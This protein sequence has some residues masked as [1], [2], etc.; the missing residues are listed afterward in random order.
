MCVFTCA[1]VSKIGHCFKVWLRY[2]APVPLN[3]DTRRVRS[4]GR[5]KSERSSNETGST[6]YPGFRGAPSSGF[7]AGVSID[8]RAAGCSFTTAGKKY[9]SLN[10]PLLRPLSNSRAA[11]HDA[12]ESA[13]RACNTRSAPRILVLAVEAV[14]LDAA[15]RSISSLTIDVAF[16]YS[17]KM[18]R[19]TSESGGARIRR[20]RRRSPRG[21]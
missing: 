2:S 4:V 5:R 16:R 1:A 12:L 10:F 15:A 14:D 11:P 18:R 3:L 7:S 9:P 13:M 20:L 21:E 6:G 8:A 19:A 17:S